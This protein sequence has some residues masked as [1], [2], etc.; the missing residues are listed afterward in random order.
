MSE[1]IDSSI[2][3]I[4]VNAYREGFELFIYLLLVG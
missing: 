1:M 4:F 3:A 2:G